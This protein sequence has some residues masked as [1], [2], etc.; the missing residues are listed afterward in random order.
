MVKGAKNVE[1]EMVQYEI[2]NCKRNISFYKDQM[3]KNEKNREFYAEQIVFMENKLQNLQN[4]SEGYEEAEEVIN[5]IRV[6]L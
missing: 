3:V 1:Q 5:K 6:F 4:D 2:Q